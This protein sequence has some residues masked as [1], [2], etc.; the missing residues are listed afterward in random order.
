MWSKLLLAFENIILYYKLLIF[1]IALYMQNDTSP[2]I[3]NHVQNEINIFKQIM[4]C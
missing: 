3:F 1:I 4:S 2:T